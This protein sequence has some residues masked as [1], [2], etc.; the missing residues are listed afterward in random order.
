MRLAAAVTMWAG[1]CTANP[2]PIRPC[3][4]VPLFQ[5]MVSPCRTLPSLMVAGMTSGAAARVTTAGTARAA[6][7]AGAAAAGRIALTARIEAAG[8]AL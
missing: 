4:A 5:A 2:N 3:C 6:R 1:G 8:T 7:R